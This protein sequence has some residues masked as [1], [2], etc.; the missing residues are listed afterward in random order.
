MAT[1]SELKFHPNPSLYWGLAS[2]VPYYDQIGF[3]FMGV[4]FWGLHPRSSPNVYIANWE[5]INLLAIRWNIIRPYPV[6]CTLK[7]RR[8]GRAAAV[9]L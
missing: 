4:K 3:G 9:K 6:T 2:F 8:V 1:L 5:L 7:T